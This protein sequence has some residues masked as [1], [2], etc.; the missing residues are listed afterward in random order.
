MS[1]IVSLQETH[2]G[3]ADY[4]TEGNGLVG[5]DG[6]VINGFY[7]YKSKK[8]KERTNKVIVRL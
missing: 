5:T 7:L 3:K 4:H 6:L 2:E 1:T 8:K